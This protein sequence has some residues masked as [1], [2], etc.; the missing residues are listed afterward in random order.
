MCS[1]YY[2]DLQVSS[3]DWSLT[4]SF[5]IRYAYVEFLEV[6]AVQNAILLSESELHN[7]PLK[8]VML[9][10]SG[11]WN[12]ILIVVNHVFCCFEDQF[13]AHKVLRTYFYPLSRIIFPECFHTYDWSEVAG[14]YWQVTAKRTNVPGMKG[15][16][17]RPYAPY[18]GYRPRRPFSAPYGYAPYGS[19][20]SS[21]VDSILTCGVHI[22]Y[23]VQSLWLPCMW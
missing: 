9:P 10:S 8:V 6:E 2:H 11:I 7:R 20:W 15:Y 1:L 5:A 13:K 16:R 14:I 12:N 18:Y 19:G 22:S 23:G 4:L 21:L 17:G 3:C